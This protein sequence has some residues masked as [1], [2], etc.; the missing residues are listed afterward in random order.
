MEKL[1]TIKILNY[2]RKCL[3]FE[4]TNQICKFHY[5][6]LDIHEKLTL[7]FKCHFTVEN[8]NTIITGENSIFIC[9]FKTH[10]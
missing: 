10:T 6:I 1:R 8:L 2:I 7:L 4:E 3:L 9:I 5:Y